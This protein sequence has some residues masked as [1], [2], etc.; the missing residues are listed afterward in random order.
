MFREIFTEAIDKNINEKYDFTDLK[1]EFEGL[2]TSNNYSRDRLVATF[3]F[4][5]KSEF[6][7]FT[8]IIDNYV[9]SDTSVLRYDTSYNKNQIILKIKQ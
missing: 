5:N 6:K 2:K 1:N 4:K 7:K 8:D 9:G 3:G